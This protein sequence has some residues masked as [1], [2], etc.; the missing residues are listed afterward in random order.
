MNTGGV[1]VLEISKLESA[2]GRT[3]VLDLSVFSPEVSISGSA[4]EELIPKATPELGAM[5]LV[6]T[7]AG[8][9]STPPNI[10]VPSRVCTSCTGSGLVT[11]ILRLRK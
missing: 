10:S 1:G 11:E 3:G 8:G 4:V 7:W 2:M 9:P 5:R 6:E